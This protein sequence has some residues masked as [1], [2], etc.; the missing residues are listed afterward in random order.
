[1]IN[2]AIKYVYYDMLLDKCRLFKSNYLKNLYIDGVL[3]FP[4]GGYKRYLY[5]AHAKFTN[6]SES[7]YIKYGIFK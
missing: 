6:S 4:G 1:M 7:I 5:N 3:I 2:D